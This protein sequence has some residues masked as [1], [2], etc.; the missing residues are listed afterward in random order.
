MSKTVPELHQSP[1]CLRRS[2]CD[3]LVRGHPNPSV[4]GTD[5]PIL[6]PARAAR[7]RQVGA[8]GRGGAGGRGSREAAQYASPLKSR[9]VWKEMKFTSWA[10]LALSSPERLSTR[11]S[12]PSIAM[13]A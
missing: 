9:T 10:F 3:L 1:G 13:L 12:S 11:R 7:K 8:R 2:L 6:H 4:C 5:A